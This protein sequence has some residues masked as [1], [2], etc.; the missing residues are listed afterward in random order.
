[1]TI[2]KWV[3]DNGG[4]RYIAP[5]L[6]VSQSVFYSYLRGQYCPNARIA[7]KWIELSKGQITLKQIVSLYKKNN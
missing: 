7:L 6:D 5:L 2:E 3:K 4:P 1:M